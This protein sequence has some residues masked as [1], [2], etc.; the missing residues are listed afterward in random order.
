[1]EK[2][3]N[4]I[5]LGFMGS[6]KTSVGKLLAETLN[7][8]FLDLDAEIEKNNGLKVPEIFAKFGEKHFRELESR[9]IENLKGKERCVISLGGGAFCSQKNIDILK[10]VGLTVWLK[11]DFALIISRLGREET[12][13]RPLL[14][15]KEKAEELLK[16]REQFYSQADLVIETGNNKPGE[17]LD[18]LNHRL[19]GLKDYTD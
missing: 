6:G 14:R 9:E 11:A 5:L 18:N 10:Q 3:K 7:Y 19:N 12:E 15:E 8:R 4:I 2:T 16:S 17:I 13:K 1:M